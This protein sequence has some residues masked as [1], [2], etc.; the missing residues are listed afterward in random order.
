MLQSNVGSKA[1]NIVWLLFRV[2]IAVQLVLVH[3]LKKLGIGIETAEI[4]PNPFNLPESIN[5]IFATGANIIMPLFII[6]GLFAR[7]AS[8]PILAVTLT[9]YFIVHGSDPLPE[10]DIPFMYSISFLMIAFLGAGKYSL[11]NYLFEKK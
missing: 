3:G 7:F 2:G 5:E 4:V 8:L 9:G 11:D 10:R 1:N 6:F